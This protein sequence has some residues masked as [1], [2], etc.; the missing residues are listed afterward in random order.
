MASLPIVY[1]CNLR[2]IHTKFSLVLVF[3]S[4]IC[5]K[6]ERKKSLVKVKKK[7]GPKKKKK[8][9]FDDEWQKTLADSDN[10]IIGVTGLTQ[11]LSTC[12]TQFRVWLER[13]YLL[14]ICPFCTKQLGDP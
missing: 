11:L 2:F 6:K 5:T 3:T 1:A 7:K 8:K 9:V 10:V 12:N 4:P 13:V 14:G